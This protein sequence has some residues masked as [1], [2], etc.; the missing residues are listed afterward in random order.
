MGKWLEI[1]S[2]RRFGKLEVIR[3]GNLFIQPSGQRQRGIDCR[4]DCGTEKTIRLSHLVHNRVISCGCEIGESH[5][6]WESHLYRI[7]RSII[8]RC[9]PR[10]SESEK[11]SKRGITVVESWK[12]SFTAFMEWSLENGYKRDLTID[13]ED[14]DKGYSPENCRWV[15]QAVNN[16]NRRNTVYI[17]YENEKVSAH[18][19]I[20]KLGRKKDRATIMGR[21]R[22]GMPF[23]EAMETPIR[24]GRYQH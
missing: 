6:M 15:T 10:Y 1:K 21:L 3:E 16:C 8:W 23:S 17:V 14:N 20:E 12:S 11:Y 9:D 5:G 2:G 13:R 24:I 7:W 22:R 18:L 19:L 4:C